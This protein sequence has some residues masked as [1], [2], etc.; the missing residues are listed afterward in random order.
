MR[1]VP[2]RTG[3]NLPRV[4]GNG[5]AA[6]RRFDRDHGVTTQALFFLSQLGDAGGPAYARATHYEPVPVRSFRALLSHVPEPFLRTSVF[7]DVGS[8]MG[9]AVLLASEYPFKQVLGIELSPSLHAIAQTNLSSAAD[10][11]TR[12]RDVRLRCGDARRARFPKG[13]LVIFLFNPFDDEALR[14]VLDRILSSRSDWDEVLLLYYVPVHRDVLLERESETV[15]EPAEGLV[16]RFPARRG[17]FANK[18]SA[19]C[20]SR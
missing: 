12:C 2:G 20:R 11:P 6:G 16:T 19:G 1:A 18:C 10:I 9:R 5:R 4:T 15:A 7:V 14:C 13:D 8:G 17:L 3:Q